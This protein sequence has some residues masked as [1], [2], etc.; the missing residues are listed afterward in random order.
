MLLVSLTVSS[1][2][3]QCVTTQRANA[4]IPVIIVVANSCKK[5]PTATADDPKHCRGRCLKQ[6]GGPAYDIVDVQ[7]TLE[8]NG[9]TV[10]QNAVP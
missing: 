8:F 5:F 4:E 9:V 2:L 1:A 10:D 7:G 3:Q 6:L